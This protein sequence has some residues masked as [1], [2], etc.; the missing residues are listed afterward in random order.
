MAP[1]CM[2]VAVEHCMVVPVTLLPVVLQV[3]A[4]MKGGGVQAG[5]GGILVASTCM[6]RK[7]RQRVNLCMRLSN[8]SP[9]WAC[10]LITADYKQHIHLRSAPYAHWQYL[11]P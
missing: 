5:A 2:T 3:T 10:L 9:N 4:G 7:G 8:S 1:G 6:G 11:L